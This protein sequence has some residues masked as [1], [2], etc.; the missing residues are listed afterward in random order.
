MDI[1]EFKA[2]IYKQQYQHKSF[3]PLIVNQSWTWSDAK[4]NI[5][6][7]EATHKLGELNAFSL[8][9]PDID[10]FIRMHVIKEATTSSKIEGTKT[11]VKEALQKKED[12][13]PENKDDWQEVQNYVK[14]MD[15]AIDQLKHLPLSTRLL[16]EAHGRLM[17]GVRGMEKKP[18][19]YRTSQNWIGGATINDAI[20]IPPHHEELSALMGDLENFLHDE[21]IDVPHLIKIAIA[22][23]Q[24]ETIHPFLDGNGRIGRLMITLY[25]VDKGL[26][27][28]PTL[29]LSDYFERNKGLYY[30]NLTLVRTSHNLGQWIKF[31]LVAVIETSKKGI[32]TFQKILKL[33]E[34]IEGEKIV[35]LGKKVSKA[36]ELMNVLYR[37]PY[38]TAADIMQG[39]NITAPTANV[40]IQDFV[41][42][43]ILKEM[44]GKKRNRM[45]F[46]IEYLRLF[47]ERS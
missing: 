45:F 41:R 27:A 1:K 5:L 21:Q 13:R 37:T 14:A 26:L 8:Y 16:K 10:I 33:K 4:L 24:F 23:Y 29:Y 15:G 3:S 9:V 17:H 44:T 18:G 32:S 11:N 22:H 7:E 31:F 2:G 6:L 34:K 46:F 43:G 12:I 19:E 28:K 39:L 36:R 40:L 42:L 20:F 38:V 35:T 47:S 30:E 25:L